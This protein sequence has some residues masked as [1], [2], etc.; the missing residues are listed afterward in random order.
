MTPLAWLAFWYLALAV[1]FSAAMFVAS[2]FDA[3]RRN[4]PV[5]GRD[6]GALP[7]ASV[8]PAVWWRDLW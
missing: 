2:K 1:V 7:V 5:I 4:L 3:R 6:V 8:I